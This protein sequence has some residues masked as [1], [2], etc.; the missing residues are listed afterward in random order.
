MTALQSVIPSLNASAKL[1]KISWSLNKIGKQ[2]NLTEYKT[3]IMYSL[4][5]TCFSFLNAYRQI[6]PVRLKDVLW[7]PVVFFVFALREGVVQRLTL[8]HLDLAGHLVQ[9]FPTF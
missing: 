5:S 6:H 1:L 9:Y 2:L 7:V 4:S 3:C 8:L